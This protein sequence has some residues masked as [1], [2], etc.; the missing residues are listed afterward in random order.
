LDP[1]DR[2]KDNP[3]VLDWNDPEVFK[4]II[5]R[6]IASSTG[7][8]AKFE[9]LW[10]FFF[11]SHVRGQ[12]SFAYILDRT[13]SRP[14]EV[15]RF[16]KDSIDVAVNRGHESVREEDILHAEASYSDDALVDLTLEL[17][18]V[19]PEFSNVPYAFIGTSFT[20]S[21]KQ[22][23]ALIASA[24]VNI[25]AARKVLELLLWFG[26]LGVQ[27]YP[28]EERYAYQYQHNLQKMH[29]GTSLSGYS[30]HPAFRRALG[31]AEN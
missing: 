30:I 10:L 4:E 25:S 24:G 21:E 28:D 26:F 20:L 1:A 23:E 18:D 6:R 29:S 17:K 15:L 31:S 11:A 7:L 14:R 27:V 22:V 5:R 3:V 16:V 12:E 19:S 13:L 8:D 9:E 2:G